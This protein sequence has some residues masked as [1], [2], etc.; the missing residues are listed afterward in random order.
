MLSACRPCRP[1]GPAFL[2]FLFLGALAGAARLGVEVGEIRLKARN[3]CWGRRV[4]STAS[5]SPAGASS[6]LNKVM[7]SSLVAS[8]PVR[9]MRWT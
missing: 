6:G 2:A 1:P 9:L 8:A 3:H 4:S 7:A 5:T